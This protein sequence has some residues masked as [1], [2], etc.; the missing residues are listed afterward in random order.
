MMENETSNPNGRRGGAFPPTHWS[1]VLAAAG[2]GAPQASRALAELCEAYWSPL[3]CFLRRQG[4][5]PEEAEDLTQEFLS[6]LV[7]KEVLAG[8]T[9]EGGKFRSF[10]L[11]VLKRFLANEWHHQHAQKRGG[12]QEVIS[13]DARVE[14]GY[15]QELIDHATPETVFERQWAFTVLNRVMNQLREEYGRAGKGDLFA[16]LQSCLPGTQS[17]AVPAPAGRGLKMSD[18]ALRMAAYR[19]RRRY[20]QL[21]RAEIATTVASPAEIDEEIQHLIQV[22]SRP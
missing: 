10:L 18:A 19:L 2:A 21:L 16:R 13:I 8:L 1:L 20:G 22:T 12:G 15:Q 6:R 4:Y 5:S 3:Y 7:H 14:A 17:Q 11:T 9:Q